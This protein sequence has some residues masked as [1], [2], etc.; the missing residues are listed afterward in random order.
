MNE[1]VITFFDNIDEVLFSTDITACR[2]TMIT[3]ACQKVY[4]YPPSDFLSNV[5]LWYELVLDQDKHI[6]DNN[7]LP[8]SSGEIIVQEY[9]IRHKDGSIR[10]L[11]SKLYPIINSSGEFVQL[12]GISADVTARKEAQMELAKFEDKFRALIINSSDAITLINDKFE[13]EF[14]SDS[15]E[16]ITGF[17][18]DDVKGSTYRNYVHPDDIAMVDRVFGELLSSQGEPVRLVYRSKKKDGSYYWCER[19]ATNLLHKPEVNGI[20]SN[21][22]DIT[23]RKNIEDELQ[24]TNQNLKKLNMELDRFVYSASHDLRAPLSSMLGLLGIVTERNT[25]EVIIPDLELIKKC[26]YKLDSFILEILDYSKNART[27]PA[28]DQIFFPEELEGI[29]NNLKF[30]NGREDVPEIEVNVNGD[31]PFYSDKNRIGIIMGN[32][33]SNAFQYC[34]TDIPNPIVSITVNLGGTGAEIIVKDN[35][36]GIPKDLQHKAFDMFSRLSKRSTGSGL[37][38]YIVKETVAMLDGTISISSEEGMG[39]EVTVIIPN[40][41]G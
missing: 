19:V 17:T 4:G 27:T 21:Y 29:I 41:V 38:L 1:S 9:R 23:D 32:L 12:N 18:P 34:R 25:C 39:T 26:I 36:I 31:T 37:G 33:I 30:I 5:S 3:A 2:C 35:G 11:E 7:Q 13:V 16:R 22:R 8:L 15:M 20:I 40:V 24:L 6:I 10:W 14:A 28:H